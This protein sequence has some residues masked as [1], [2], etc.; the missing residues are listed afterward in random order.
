MPRHGDEWR[1]AY[2]ALLQRAVEGDARWAGGLRALVELLGKAGIPLEDVLHEHLALCHSM[3]ADSNVQRP[4]PRPCDAV[5][6]RVVSALAEASVHRSDWPHAPIVSHRLFDEIPVGLYRTTHDGQ[7]LAANSTL[8]EMLGSADL[9]ALLQASALD[10]YVHPEQR[11]R[12]LAEFGRSDSVYGVEFEMRRCDGRR[13]WVSD[14]AH[15]VRDGRGRVLFYEGVL[16]DITERKRAERELHERWVRLESLVAERTRELEHAKD[17]AERELLERRRAE[18]AE[19]VSAARFRQL[20]DQSPIAAAIVALDGRF[21]RVNDALCA[22][23]GYDEQELVGRRLSEVS[24][25]DDGLAIRLD[26]ARNMRLGESD[27][28]VVDKRFVRKDGQVLWVRASTRAIRDT[29]GRPVHF[30]ALLQDITGER[31]AAE[32]VRLQRDLGVALLHAA[33]LWEA[34]EAILDA[35]M[36]VEGVDAGGVYIVAPATGD[37]TLVTHRG[38]SPAFLAVVGVLSADTP[39]S[40]FVRQGVPLYSS[41]GESP[42]TSDLLKSEGLR[43]LASIPVLH[44]GRAVACLNVASRTREVLPQATRDALELLASRVGAVVGRMHD[45][46]ALEASERLFRTLMDTIPALAVIIEDDRVAYINNAGAAMLGYSAKE[47]IGR[48]LA[49]FLPPATREL[50]VRRALD[51]QAGREAPPRYELPVLTRDGKELW[52]DMSAARIE[53]ENRPAALGVALDITERRRVEQSL[54]AMQERLEAATQATELGVWDWNVATGEVSFSDRWQTMLGYEPGEVAPNYLSWENSLHPDDKPRV[55]EALRNHL[56]GRAPDY[57]VEMRLRTKS[58]DWK[59]VLASGKVVLR[60]AAGKPLRMT[61]TH[62]DISARKEAE[63]LARQHSEQ[64]AH[65][66]RVSTIGEMASTLAHEMAQPLSAILYYAQGA[67]ARMRRDATPARDVAA[68]FEKISKQAAR[69]GEFIRQIKAFVRNARPTHVLGDANEP[70]IDA[71]ALAEPLIRQNGID[72]RLDLG[73]GL[74]QVVMDKIQIEQVILN[75]VRNAVEAMEQSPRAGRRLEVRT[76]LVQD[77][78]IQYV[79][80][81]AGPGI[82]PDAAARL[83]EPFFTTKPGGTGLGLPMSRSIIEAHD[84]TLRIQSSECG[85]TTVSFTLPIATESAHVNT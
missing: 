72:L 65:V 3:G 58:G 17:A 34:L 39:Q 2:A 50:V 9:G 74:P 33:N 76:A 77:H 45:R 85:G 38:L 61:G 28:G 21:E 30:F 36:Q 20:F 18:E 14:H 80:S 8:V 16:L 60:D 63:E 67:A 53:Y 64:L 51:R 41:A 5:L 1:A 57:A 47:V 15:A 82:P 69:A 52:L 26:D 11:A 46:E 81:D 43:S 79:V 70:V 24:Y 4:D 35:A 32:L 12:K 25:D 62:L 13:I 27:A 29:T 19:R 55:M 83:F 75:L 73:Q 23:L 84:G 22:L 49:E 71:I 68:I 10:F 44:A 31:R 40:R 66:S 78:F 6:G 7:I 59:W 56:T 42:Y 37:L 48:P 54:R